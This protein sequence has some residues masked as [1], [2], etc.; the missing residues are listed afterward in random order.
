MELVTKHYAKFEYLNARN[1]QNKFGERTLNIVSTNPF[2]LE[3]PA[4]TCY[5]IVVYDIVETKIRYKGREI[6]LQSLPQDSTTYCIGNR[7]ST[8]DV[9]KQCGKASVVYDKLTNYPNLFNGAFIDVTGHVHPLMKKEILLSSENL[10]YKRI[11]DE[12][13]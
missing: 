5:R 6:V 3:I 9:G 4:K 7:I 1:P 13:D 8:A 11:E 12:N 2:D 10:H